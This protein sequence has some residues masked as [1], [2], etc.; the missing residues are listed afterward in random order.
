MIGYRLLS[1][2]FVLEDIYIEEPRSMLL[3]YWQAGAKIG[4]RVIGHT[5]ATG[6]AGSSLEWVAPDGGKRRSR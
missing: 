4:M 6:L 2:Y 5:P 3:A 1:A